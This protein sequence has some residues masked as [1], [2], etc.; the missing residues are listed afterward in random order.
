M[1]TDSPA[2][3]WK[4]MVAFGWRPETN[5]LA[6]VIKAL[7]QSAL[8]RPTVCVRGQ[9]REM[10]DQMLDIFDMR[11]DHDLAVM[12]PNQRLA[13]RT[14]QAGASGGWGSHGERKT[15]IEPGEGRTVH[16]DLV[17][18]RGGVLE[19]AVKA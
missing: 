17:E 2:H 10:L 12:Q 1:N 6:P 7:E 16:A 18:A 11:P 13:D 9:H 15:I 19:R 3:R 14:R 5:K 8:L 4:V